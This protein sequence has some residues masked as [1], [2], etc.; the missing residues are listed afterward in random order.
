[1]EI[2]A[3]LRA[4]AELAAEKRYRKNSNMKTNKH[5]ANEDVLLKNLYQRKRQAEFAPDFSIK[6]ESVEKLTRQ[7]DHLKQCDE[8]LHDPNF[9]MEQEMVIKSLDIVQKEIAHKTTLRNYSAM[10]LPSKR[11]MEMQI[12]NNGNN[13][14]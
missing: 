12:L 2:K 1:M 5:E 13:I 14:T 8:E 10:N 9:K 4:K 11:K 6:S 7:M 3:I